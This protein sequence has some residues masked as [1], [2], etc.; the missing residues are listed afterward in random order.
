MDSY[1]YIFGLLALLFLFVKY[2][3]RKSDNYDEEDDCDS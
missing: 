1:Y 3:N 2:V